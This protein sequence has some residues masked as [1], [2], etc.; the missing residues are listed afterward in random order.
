MGGGDSRE[1]RREM[2]AAQTKEV[3]GEVGR[4]GWIW[5]VLRAEP[6]SKHARSANRA[7]GRI[8]CFDP[9]PRSSSLGDT[10]P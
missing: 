2:R 8:T 9:F 3:V 6:I 4:S 5:G 1:A 7:G 10:V